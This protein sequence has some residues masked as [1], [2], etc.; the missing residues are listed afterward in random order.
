LIPSPKLRSTLSCEIRPLRAGRAVQPASSQDTARVR[1]SSARWLRIQAARTSGL[2]SA[3]CKWCELRAAW[4]I[5]V[6]TLATLSGRCVRHNPRGKR[7]DLAISAACAGTGH[8]K[9]GPPGLLS[10]R[11]RFPRALFI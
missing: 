11:R 7:Y 2:L 5:R 3:H 6:L 1:N 8:D 4:V 10:A 9:T